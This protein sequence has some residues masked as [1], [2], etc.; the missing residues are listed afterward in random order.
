MSHEAEDW[1]QKLL[2]QPEKVRAEA[3][4]RLLASLD[5]GAEG[6]AE[7]ACRGE[8]ERRVR[9]ALAGEASFASWDEVRARLARRYAR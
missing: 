1:V 3:A 8:I 4:A 6:G 9:A 7:A 5:D 2:G